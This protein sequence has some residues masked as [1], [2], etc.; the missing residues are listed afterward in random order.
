MRPNPD[1]RQPATTRRQFAELNFRRVSLQHSPDARSGRS[2]IP[3][4]GLLKPPTGEKQLNHGPTQTIRIW[5]ATTRHRFAWVIDLSAKQ[6][7]VWRLEKLPVP[8]FAF[9]GDKSPA[10]SA[11]KSAHSREVAPSPRCADSCPFV[12]RRIQLRMRAQLTSSP[13]TLGARRRDHPVRLENPQPPSG[14]LQKLP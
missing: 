5:S 8:P 13:H 12:V 6:G 7:R 2:A 1:C 14:A 11:D 10:K 9:D 4:C 3:G